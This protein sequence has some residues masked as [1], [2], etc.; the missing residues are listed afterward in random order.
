MEIR[1]LLMWCPLV[2]LLLFLV[3]DPISDSFMCE[4]DKD[5]R[6]FLCIIVWQPLCV[7]FTIVMGV[8]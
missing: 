1:D 4:R 2:G 7:V 3:D 5:L 6:A 8:I